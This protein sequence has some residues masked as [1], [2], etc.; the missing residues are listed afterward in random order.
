MAGHYDQLDVALARDA[1]DL[2]SRISDDDRGNDS[3]WISAISKADGCRHQVLKRLLSLAAQR[4][5]PVQRHRAR[6]TEGRA[7]ILDYPEQQD[8]SSWSSER[9]CV[10]KRVGG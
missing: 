7:H 3:A 8:F 1:C 9:L 4:F 10:R 2:L 6:V 5:I